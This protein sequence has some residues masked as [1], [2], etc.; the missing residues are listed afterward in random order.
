MSE[1]TRLQFGAV[2]EK[3][4]APSRKLSKII[5]SKFQS[6]KDYGLLIGINIVQKNIVEG[7]RPHII[8]IT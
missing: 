8:S 5:V 3:Q 1:F 7:Q 6:V 4:N 2:I